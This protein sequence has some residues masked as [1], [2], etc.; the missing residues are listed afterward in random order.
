MYVNILLNLIP[1]PNLSGHINNTGWVVHQCI[2]EW[3]E[4]RRGKRFLQIDVGI[5]RMIP[6]HVY[7]DIIYNF[8][9]LIKFWKYCSNQILRSSILLETF[10]T[11]LNWKISLAM[12]IFVWKVY[13][14]RMNLQFWIDKPLRVLE[15]S[16]WS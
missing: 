11:T 10:I 16:L 12:R 14:R 13:Q 3:P 6:N 4:G 1:V 2:V 7:M 8:M 9:K 15:R 5:L